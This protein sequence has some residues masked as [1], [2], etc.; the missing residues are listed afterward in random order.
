M[1]RAH[2]GYDGGPVTLFG[3]GTGNDFA[4]KVAQELGAPVTA[5]NSDA[6]VDHDGNV[7]ASNQSPTYEYGKPPKPTWPPNGEWTTHNPTG[8]PTVHKGPYPPGHTPTWGEK[9]PS[10]PIGVAAHRGDG[11]P[12][13]TDNRTRQEERDVTPPED[14]SRPTG[15]EHR[16]DPNHSDEPEHPDDSDQRDD[17]EQTDDSNQQDD[18]DQRDDQDTSG[19]PRDE[20]GLTTEPAPTPEAHRDKV[21]E[22]DTNDAAE[23]FLLLCTEYGPERGGV[24]VFN[25]SLAEALADAGHNVVV[26][27]GEDP[28]PYADAQRPNLTIL[29]PKD[30]PPNKDDSGK[31]L[32]PEHDPEGMPKH[33]DYVVGHTRFSGPDARATRDANYSDAK[34]I[35]FVHMVPEALGRVKEDTDPGMGEEA[36]GIQNHAVERDLVAGA[37]LAVGVGPAITENV[38]EMVDQARQMGMPVATQAVHELIPGMDF[39]ERRERS[40]EGRP[41]NVFLFGRTDVGQKGATQAAEVVAR[42]HQTGHD[43]K[44]T[45]RGVPAHLVSEQKLALEEITDVDVD[46]RPFTTDRSDLYADLDDADVMVMT[47]RA[48]GFGLTAQEAAAAGVPVMA[49]SSSGFGRWLGESGEFSPE[50]TGPSIVEQ[51]FEDRV[52]VD[53]WYDALKDVVDDYPAAQR[54]ALDLQQEFKDR[55]VTWGTAVGPLVDKARRLQ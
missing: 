40:T 55:K 30:P 32:G 4:G 14:R 12:T 44:L 54:R 11:P 28:T 36:K 26:R 29:G 1:I 43:V 15:P 53:R 22:Q 21:D 39:R 46:V 49:P 20:Q 7:F 34:L 5:P 19:T 13:P 45:V 31:F 51:G 8:E 2:P 41:V 33:V 10:R 38:H 50:L 9:T 35:H 48:E 52:P 6:W 3:C 47:S 25:R 37:D 27:I 16:D 17:S 24:V 23:T 18:S 42:L